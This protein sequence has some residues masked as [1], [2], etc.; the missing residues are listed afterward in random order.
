LETIAQGLTTAKLAVLHAG[1]VSVDDIDLPAR[2]RGEVDVSII[3]AALCGSDLHTIL[4]HRQA[5]ERMALGHEGVGRVTDADENARDLTG[6]RLRC[7]DRVVFSMLSSCGR[8]APCAAGLTMKCL[9]GFKYGHES[10]TKAPFAS[11]TL[12][13]RVRLLPSVPV[14]R[15]P[16]AVTDA[17]VVSAGCAVATAAAIVSSCQ[18]LASRPHRA[19]VLGAGAV[20][21]YTAAMLV[22]AG[23]EADVY[24]PRTDRRSAAE[25]VGAR[26]VSAP[27]GPYPLVVEASGSSA[28]VAEAVRLADLGGRVVL[29]GSVSPGHS[30][31]ALDPAAIVTRRLT[32]VGVHNY[33]AADFRT[34]VEWLIARGEDRSLDLLASPPFL[35]TE[36]ER[37]VETMSTGTFARVLV[38]PVG[39]HDGR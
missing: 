20:G 39:A 28:A 27:E 10:V 26:P 25:R 22:S 37:A 33:T 4:G 1:R 24:D 23:C 21:V 19:I 7:G 31:V 13:D 14:M 12:A 29:A 17:Q 35:L 15:V 5:P 9:V 6:A 18:P 11:G 16:D 30:S 2:S 8:C 36:V 38:R 32:L 3:I 34:G